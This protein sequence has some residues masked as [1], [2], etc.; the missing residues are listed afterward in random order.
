[1]SSSM[2]KS[3]KSEMFIGPFKQN[4]TQ[5][6]ITEVHMACLYQYGFKQVVRVN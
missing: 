4:R 2:Y 1:M 3:E 5:I 6:Y